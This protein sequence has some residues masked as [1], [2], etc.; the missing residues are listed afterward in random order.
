MIHVQDGEALQVINPDGMRNTVEQQMVSLLGL[1]KC[2]LRQLALGNDPEDEHD[3]EAFP[4]TRENGRGTIFD[5]KLSAVLG[6]QKRMVGQSHY[7]PLAEYFLDGVLDG[8]ATFLV[9]NIKH[10]IHGFA[11]R[12]RLSPA[13]DGLGDGIQK[14]HS[15]LHVRGD[16]R[17]TN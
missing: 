13:V 5:V 11:V 3:S 7:L 2:F 10:Q 16:H 14:S 4:C 17:V 9:Y 1:A 6:E 8:A 12:L 15:A